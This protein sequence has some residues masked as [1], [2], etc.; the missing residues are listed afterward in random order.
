MRTDLTKEER[1]RLLN[2][3]LKVIGEDETPA[4]PKKQKL[5]RLKK[6]YRRFRLKK[7]RRG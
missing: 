6:H 2:F 3:Y 1:S 7:S 5:R 4:K